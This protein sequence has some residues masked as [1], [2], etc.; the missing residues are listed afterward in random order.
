M[1]RWRG[2]LDV[3]RLFLSG[4][5]GRLFLG[6]V[7]AAVTVL[8]GVALLGLSGWFITGTALAGAG[9]AIAHSFDVFRPSAGIRFL[10]LTRTAARYGERLA[11]HDATLALL[12]ALRERLFRGYAG[13]GAGRSLLARPSRLLF[14]LTAE[15][16]A[17]DNLYLR[18]LVPG[19]AALV[20]ALAT[21]YGL[22]LLDGRLGLG[23]L[24]A[25]LLPGLGLPI[26]LARAA[27]RMARRRASALE[28][29]RARGIDVVAG[30]ADLLMAGRLGAQVAAAMAA[31]Q[32]L[33]RADDE[34]NRMETTATVGFSVSGTLILTAALVAAAGLVEASTISVPQAALV[35]L[36]AMAALEPFAA[37][38]RGA[39]ELGRTAL[40]ARRL[41]P[42][43]EG[44]RRPPRVDVPPGGKALCLRE[45]TFRHPSAAEPLFA[46]L[47]LDVACGE[48]VALIG[49]SGAG[50]STLLA[51]LQGE[52][53][54]QS[55]EVAAARR[56]VLGQ[57]T[58]LFQDNLRGN[59]LL[60]NPQAD[61]AR[62]WRAL[63]EAQLAEVVRAL[64]QGLDTPLGEGGAGL[65]GGQRRRLALARM[66]LRD[67][68]L[69]LLDE[70]TEG[71][72]A[73]NAK[74]ILTWIKARP[75]GIAI[76]AVT[77]LRREAE[78]ADRL[79]RLEE[80]RLVAGWRRGEPGFD[81]AL[82]ALR[83]D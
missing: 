60:A 42:A 43:L 79:L 64:P 27:E 39:L 78:I 17:L 33:A 74:A 51:L 44:E 62:L 77:H 81:A 24:L 37:L 14:R 76:F 30:Q 11:T 28:A 2:L 12:A 10:A 45:V 58:E 22:G 38:R 19:V 15:V 7:L 83:P 29:L 48:R 67:A 46:G 8:A 41:A 65:S 52:A 59:L 70:P 6:A 63:E 66:L 32:R 26:A 69:W 3:L 16:D 57:R 9:A 82:A 72:D 71:L 56:A 13:S 80:G 50:K 20:T 4:R 5:R 55:G 1:S 53:A 34:L 54:P 31:E 61:D 36:V 35:L 21:G 75:R 40:A 47:S 23:L 25:L 49:P 68:P 73:A 18:V